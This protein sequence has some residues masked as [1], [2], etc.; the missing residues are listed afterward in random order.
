M[1]NNTLYVAQL[2]E[3]KPLVLA[4]TGSTPVT[5]KE[6]GS[7]EGYLMAPLL[8]K[9][10]MPFI[11]SAY[12]KYNA[13]GIKAVRDWMDFAKLYT[14]SHEDFGVDIRAVR[15]EGAKIS[16]SFHEVEVRP[17]WTGQ[18]FPFDTVTI[19]IR[20]RKIIKE[21]WDQLFF[22]SV[23]ADLTMGMHV[24]GYVVALS[25]YVEKQTTRGVEVF[26]SVPIERY[27]HVNLVT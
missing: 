16:H 20:K 10:K 14:M 23:S 27:T 15:I 3:H 21:H 1:A 9:E 7:W 22:W 11:K 18:K 2:V 4:V 8:F 12:D 25:D 13:P 6:Q 24:P 17:P 19:P 5:Q 26:F